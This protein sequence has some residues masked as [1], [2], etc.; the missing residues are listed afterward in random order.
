MD[1][2][3]L[4]AAFVAA[5]LLT[6]SLASAQ[7]SCPTPVVV[8]TAVEIAPCV[9]VVAAP[10]PTAPCDSG[11]S[12]IEYTAYRGLHSNRTLTMY[13]RPYSGGMS[14]VAFTVKKGFNNFDGYSNVSATI[15]PCSCDKQSID[16]EPMG[17]GKFCGHANFHPGWN[18]VSVW[19]TTPYSSEMQAFNIW[20]GALKDK[21]RQ[22]SW[23]CPKCHVTTCQTSC[24]VCD[25]SPV[26]CNT[27]CKVAAPTCDTGCKTSCSNGCGSNCPCHGN[28]NGN[29][30]CHC[31]C[32]AAPACKTCP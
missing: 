13:A 16:L 24:P 3:F 31:G 11:K 5:L 1:K 25:T 20:G 6:V 22:V 2:K 23:E 28:C 21:P 27:S 30:N 19:V 17:L 26:S 7:I 9:K 12:I 32:K 18:N 29:S 8:G 15:N 14:E 4:A 10:C